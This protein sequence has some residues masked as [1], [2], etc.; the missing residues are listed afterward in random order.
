M[1]HIIDPP[2]APIAPCHRRRIDPGR[3]GHGAAARKPDGTPADTDR[4]ETGPTALAFDEWAAAGLPVPDLAAMRQWRLDRLVGQLALRGL[5]G[6]LL[7]DPLNIRYASDTTN[8]QIWAMHNQFRACL[9]CADGYLVVWDYKPHDL[10]TAFNPLVRETRGGASLLYAL[11]GDRIGEDADRFAAEVVDLL[12]ARAGDNRR[13]ALDRCNLHGVRALQAAG[14]D[15]ADGEEVMERTRAIKGPDEIRA[16]RCAVH[17]C[18]QAMAAMQQAVAPGRTEAD[19]WSVLHA[20]SIRRGGEWIETRLLASG[21]RTNPWF[22]EC[23]PRPIQAG[24]LLAFD[25]DLVGCYGFCADISRTWLVGDGPATERQRALYR[26][27]KAHIDDNTA[28]LCPGLPFAEIT[29]RGRPLPEDCRRNRYGVML[30][31]V[32]LCDEW[33]SIHYPEDRQPGRFDYHLEPGQCLCVEAYIGPEDAT[34]GVKLEQQVVITDTGAEPIS[35]FAFD[36][37]LL[38]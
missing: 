14:L 21:P 1:Q 37:R 38:A 25:T 12:R 3:P 10:L 35:R 33:P 4:V 22:Q 30:H 34:E 27:A 18:E 28:L 16:M 19:I 26:E 17:A 23:G 2:N 32:G 11:N 36:D 7:T 31:G 6:V 24:D 8:M 13:L 9:V 20:E 29:R 5:A 15:L